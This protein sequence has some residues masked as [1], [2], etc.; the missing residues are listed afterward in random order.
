MHSREIKGFVFLPKH[1]KPTVQDFL[2]FVGPLDFFFMETYNAVAPKNTTVTRN[3]SSKYL[4]Q[5]GADKSWHAIYLHNFHIFQKKKNQSTLFS[6]FS[7]L[8]VCLSEPQK[9][10]NLLVCLNS[11]VWMKKSWKSVC[12]SETCLFVS[13]WN[14]KSFLSK[15]LIVCFIIRLEKLL[16]V[17]AF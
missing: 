10:E 11:L 14:L 3:V 17:C 12:L 5:I 9:N 15:I 4:P 6:N 7:N 2:Q 13:R 1:S 16:S 8:S